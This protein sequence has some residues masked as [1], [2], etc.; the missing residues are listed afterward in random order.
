MSKVGFCEDFSKFR[1]KD[2]RAAMEEG[3]ENYLKIIAVIRQRAGGLSQDSSSGDKRIGVQ[4]VCVCKKSGIVLGIT[5]LLGNSVR[6]HSGCPDSAL[7]SH[8]LAHQE[9]GKG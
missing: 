7:G 4:G 6:S 5:S 9:L 1:W 8:H 2:G 3:R